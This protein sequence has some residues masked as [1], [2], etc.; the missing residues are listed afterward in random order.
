LLKDI[1]YGAEV[2]ISNMR[3]SSGWNAA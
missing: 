3:A 1:P 2:T